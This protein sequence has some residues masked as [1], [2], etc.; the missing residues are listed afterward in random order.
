MRG[1]VLC[2]PHCG[3]PW[4]LVPPARRRP[5]A[6]AR[7]PGE[8]WRRGGRGCWRWGSTE[9]T[10]AL[11]RMQL[12][13]PPMGVLLTAPTSGWCGQSLP[14]VTLLVAWGQK[15]TGRVLTG[16][17][18]ELSQLKLERPEKGEEKE[19]KGHLAGSCLLLQAR[20]SVLLWVEGSQVTGITEE[21]GRREGER[22]IWPVKFFW[23][24]RELRWRRDKQLE[25]WKKKGRDKERQAS[26]AS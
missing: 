16:C 22:S 18:Q 11:L 24:W 10:A 4:D 14:G 26:E 1:S 21:E 12:S 15:G 6:H 19:I 25:L 7:C 5:V 17:R 8:A 23:Q 20:E 3:P 9:A 2:A 13:V